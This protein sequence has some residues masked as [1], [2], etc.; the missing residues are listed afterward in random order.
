MKYNGGL[1]LSMSS[2]SPSLS[3]VYN[4]AGFI[5]CRWFIKVIIVHVETAG[6]ST[7]QPYETAPQ[8]T[9]TS[10]C[11]LTVG[12]CLSRAVPASNTHGLPQ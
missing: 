8:L 3:S 6:M 12:D 2:Q 7:F 10:T 1:D 9:S 5:I 4:I 11:S